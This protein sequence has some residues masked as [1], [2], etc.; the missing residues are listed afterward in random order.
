MPGV[1]TRQPQF[2]WSS[3]YTTATQ[4][5]PKGCQGWTP[6]SLGLI[7]A[8]N[9]ELQPCTQYNPHGCQGWTVDTH[10]PPFDWNSKYRA[11]TAP[12]ITLMD[13]RGGHPAASG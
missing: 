9:K 10:Q 12:S 13:A 1:D 7:G 8:Q 6:V 5:N 2:N 4:Y 11:A 3:K